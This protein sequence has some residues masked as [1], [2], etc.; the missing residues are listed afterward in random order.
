MPQM[1]KSWIILSFFLLAFGV[2]FA[3]KGSNAIDGNKILQNPGT[4]SKPVIADSINGIHRISGINLELPKSNPH[5]QIITHKGYTLSY[6]PSYHIADWVAY[7]LTAEQTVPVVERNNHFIPDPL[8]TSCSIS[9]DDYKNSGYDRGHLAPSADMCYSQQ[10]MAESFYLSNMSP[11]VP[12]FNRGIWKKLEEKV[13]QWAIEDNA[14][15]VVTGAILTKGLP[16]IGLDKITVP[17]YFYKIILDYTEPE[18]KGIG[19]I[20]PNQG[21]QE[22]LQHFVVT[23]DSVEKVTGIDFFYKLPKD[24]QRIIESTVDINEWNWTTV[25]PHQ[26]T[27]THNSGA[28][29]SGSKRCTALTKKGTRCSRMTSSPNGKC[30]QHGGD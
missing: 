29:H 3:Q 12:S 23:I 19:F 4:R 11:Q 21:S 15:F 14:V 27:N 17:E 28:I 26:N 24:Q 22:L 16:T 7:K 6:N 10:T 25:K 13:R 18:I 5:D 9:N 20:I 1:K 30:W 8:L 2:S